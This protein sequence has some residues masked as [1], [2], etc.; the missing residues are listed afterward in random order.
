M[1][2]RQIDTRLE[3]EIG[4]GDGDG[5]G[6][7]IV[8]HVDVELSFYFIRSPITKSVAVL[9]NRLLKTF[10]KC[11]GRLLSLSSDVIL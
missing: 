8:G 1:V 10:H 5:D 11:R 4:D 2:N 6:R 7:V 9:S 3:V